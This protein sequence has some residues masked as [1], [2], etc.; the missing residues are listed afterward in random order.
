MEKYLN[1]ILG[2]KQ[3]PEIDEELDEMYEDLSY[4]QIPSERRKIRKRI[5]GLKDRPRW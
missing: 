4:T 3:Y 2:K 5:D 1:K